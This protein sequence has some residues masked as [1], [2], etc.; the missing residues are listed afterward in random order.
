LA[1]SSS[2]EQFSQS[3]MTSELKWIDGFWSVPLTANLSVTHGLQNYQWGP[4]EAASPSNRIFRQPVLI[5]DLFW[6]V[7]GQHLLRF[8]YSPSER[9]TEVLLVELSDNG[10]PPFREEEAFEKKI[11]LKS[12][13]A[14]EG[15]GDYV[16]FVV[17]AHA[18]SAAKAWIGEYFNWEVRDGLYIFADVAHQKGS[19]AWYPTESAGRVLMA[20]PFANE[21]R[22]FTYAVAGLRFAF[23]SGSDLR[24]EWIFQEAGYDAKDLSN[25][26]RA[27]AAS[28][29]Q[30]QPAQAAVYPTNLARSQKSG[31]EFPGQKY[32]LFS[33]R[34]PDPDLGLTKLRDVQF[35]IRH[36]LSL[37]DSSSASFLSS[38]WRAG[39]SGTLLVSGALN[40]G[41]KDSELHAIIDSAFTAAYRHVW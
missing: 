37:T 35:Y 31:L 10:N 28:I 12:E 18:S 40:S 36:L 13:I 14:A 25:L 38:E 27:L 8:N 39:E 1:Y 22:I 9:W 4:G 15:G 33:W 26:N 20:Q 41:A 19:Q 3:N 17:G 21:S 2:A 16:G 23:T 5:R 7:A 29:F 6:V 32:V 30:T 11:V 34:V 24:G